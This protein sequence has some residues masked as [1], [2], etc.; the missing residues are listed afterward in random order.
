MKRASMYQ[1]VLKIECGLCGTLMVED[2][3]TFYEETGLGFSEGNVPP[4]A[5]AEFMRR[6]GA[7][8]V[9]LGLHDVAMRCS[10]CV[11]AGVTL[12]TQLVSIPVAEYQRLLE[13][14]KNYKSMMA[15]EERHHDRN[16]M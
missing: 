4:Q 12:K 13:I 7:D 15:A 1:M 11:K 3:T 16:G 9:P 6:R 2:M 14:E 5:I 8:Y 10:R